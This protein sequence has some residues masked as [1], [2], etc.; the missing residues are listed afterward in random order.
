RATSIGDARL[1]PIRYPA[2]RAADE[3]AA[4]HVLS[5]APAHPA[6]ALQQAYE[7]VDR[8]D[9]CGRARTQSHP[10]ADQFHAWHHE[11]QQGLQCREDAGG[12][13]QAGSLR[14]AITA[15]G[16]EWSGGESS[17]TLYSCAP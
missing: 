7:L 15:A 13:C 3:V 16:D 14:I 10:W 1:S 9:V 8:T 12:S 6:G 2:C 4:C 17:P 11:L 5:R